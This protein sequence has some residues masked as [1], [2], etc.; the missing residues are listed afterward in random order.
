MK[1]CEGEGE[2][3][4]VAERE[5]RKGKAQREGLEKSFLG[6]WS[7]HVRRLH[8]YDTRIR[9]HPQKPPPGASPPPRLPSWLHSPPAPLLGPA[10]QQSL[11][12]AP[13]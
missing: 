13:L 8:Y 10:S 12:G 5:S 3:E 2:L 9:G 1:V 6:K 7:A 11:Q 4:G